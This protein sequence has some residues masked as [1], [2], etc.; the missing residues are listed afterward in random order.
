VVFSRRAALAPTKAPSIPL[1]G[2]STI[3]G[4]AYSQRRIHEYLGRDRLRGWEQATNDNN[5]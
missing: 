4:E 3:E 5:G 2:P 1:C